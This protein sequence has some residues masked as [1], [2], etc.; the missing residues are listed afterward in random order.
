MET[1]EDMLEKSVSEGTSKNAR[2]PGVR[3][4]GKTG[5]TQKFRDAWFVG[6]IPGMVAGVWMGNLNDTPMHKVVGGKFPAQLWSDIMRHAKAK[7]G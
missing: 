4:C 1:L 6:Y 7:R 3:V 2:I 5:T